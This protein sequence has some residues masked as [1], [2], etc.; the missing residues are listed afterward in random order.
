M[1][2]RL[3]TIK[4]Q[5]SQAWIDQVK[6]AARA[7]G[8]SQNEFLLNI[9]S[10]ALGISPDGAVA[11]HG[12]RADALPKGWRSRLYQDRYQIVAKWMGDDWEISHF[13]RF[14]GDTIGAKILRADE[15]IPG[16]GRKVEIYVLGLTPEMQNLGLPAGSRDLRLVI[17]EWL[18]GQ[19]GD[20]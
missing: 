3:P 8:R 15:V 11:P 6:G 17:A 19:N 4:I 16:D 13:H 1:S 18:G 9:V 14:T 7:S 20:Q 10:Q 12:V 2:S 5:A